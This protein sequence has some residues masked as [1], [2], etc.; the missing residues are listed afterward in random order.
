MCCRRRDSGA[1]AI[2]VMWPS[3]FVVHEDAAF[4]L[5]S[6]VSRVFLSAS[7]QVVEQQAAKVSQIIEETRIVER[8]HLVHEAVTPQGGCDGRRIA[9]HDLLRN[10]RLQPA[11]VGSERL[12]KLGQRLKVRHVEI[13]EGGHE[14]LT[15]VDQR[16]VLRSASNDSTE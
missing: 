4:G 3:C 1:I 6:R 10:E 7:A 14:Q 8:R 11:F 16:R 2:T 5:G 15:L 12:F 9:V 13:A